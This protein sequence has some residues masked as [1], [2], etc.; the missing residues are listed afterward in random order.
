MGDFDKLKELAGDNQSLVSEIEAVE[1]KYSKLYSSNEDLTKQLE[2]AIGDRDE[3]DKRRQNAMK[4]IE[5]LTKQVES[6]PAGSEDQL[7]QIEQLK[8]DY[9]S[10]LNEA[11]DKVKEFE[12]QYIDS[13]RKSTF[14]ELNLAAKL[15]KDMNEEA[16]KSAIN[17]MQYDLSSQGM[18][19]DGESKTFVFKKDGVVAVNPETAKPYTPSEMASQRITSGAWSNFV[20]TT[21]AP[22][23]A[24]R[25]NVGNGGTVPSAPQV[26]RGKSS[27]FL[28]KGLQG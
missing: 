5:E 20:S 10:K 18:E 9:D 7:K 2:K 11:N 15:P 26:E 16:V 28:S 13:L 6:M 17:F 24:G 27:D 8:A 25:G 19:Y 23:G 12:S 21:P 4:Q 1:G 14:A 3:H 22:Q